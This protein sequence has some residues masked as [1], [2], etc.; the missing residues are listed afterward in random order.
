MC[1]PDDERPADGEVPAE[2]ERPRITCRTDADC[3]P[4]G[5]DA[6]CAE[7]RGLRDCTLRCDVEDDCTPPTV[8][9]VTV[10]FLTCIP[11]EGAPQRDACLPD[12]QCFADPMACI[13]GV[14]GF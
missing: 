14:P 7:W 11:D 5:A 9:G 2:E 6:V 8:V 4:Y 1:Q 12:E 3:A 13:T 10:D